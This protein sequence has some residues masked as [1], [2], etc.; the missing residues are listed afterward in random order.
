MIATMLL[1]AAQT[2]HYPGELPDCTH[3]W[4]VHDL[5]R[6]NPVKVTAD[7]GVPP[8]DAV[9]L[10]DGTEE[11]V[12]KNWCDENGGPTKWKAVNGELVCVPGSGYIFT[13]EKFGDCQLHIEWK[14]PADE[15]GEGQGRGNSGV[16]LQNE[17]EL[18]ILESFG[19]DPANMKNPNYADGQASALYGQHPPL[20]NPARKEGVWQTY[21]IIFHPAVW[22]DGKR[23]HRAS[24]TCLFN[25][26]LVHDGWELDGPTDW[27]V[28]SKPTQL[29][30]LGPLSLQD[31]GHPVPFR[32]IWIRRIPSRWAEKAHGG[33]AMCP[34]EVAKQRVRNGAATYAKVLDGVYD[35]VNAERA[36][37]AVAYDPDGGYQDRMYAVCDGLA[38]KVEGFGE[39]ELSNPDVRNDMLCIRRMCKL[40]A[41]RGLMRADSRL[42]VACE[43]A[44]KRIPKKK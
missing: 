29:P 39:K 21:D 5:N 32:N 4:S 9:V 8:S 17:Y 36:M 7:A 38:A 24:V 37:Q 35:F 34:V 11:S 6:P 3:A 20:V 26:V 40:M 2:I 27:V 43:A 41:D 18:Q 1:L 30:E 31:H 19:T 22:K 25:G 15:P 33:V 13:K 42:A 16:F 28:R 44:A 12:R 14:A 10:F 23:L